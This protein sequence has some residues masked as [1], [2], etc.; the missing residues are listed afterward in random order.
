MGKYFTMGEL[1]ASDTA[2]KKGIDNTPTDKIINNLNTLINNVLDPIR[3]KL[4][5]SISVSSGYRCPE[6]NKAVGGSK[7]SDHMD[8]NA[9]DISCY[10]NKILWDLIISMVNSKEIAVTQ[11]IDEKG[12]T[13]VHV[14]Y[15]PSNLKNQ[16]FAIK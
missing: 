13:W 7:T 1:C 16:I 5:R 8:G 9:A 10:N 11:L 2:K 3:E 14:S 6:L 15:N 4:G 12:L